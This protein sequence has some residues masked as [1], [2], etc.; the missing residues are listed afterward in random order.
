VT[1][2]VAP[3]SLAAAALRVEWRP[4]RDLEETAPAWRALAGRAL[5]A[6]VFYEPAFALAATPVFGRGA[7]AGLVW[8]SDKLIGFFPGRVTRRYGVPPAVLCGWAHP[9]AP[10][11]TPLIDRDDGAIALGAWLDW[12]AGNRSLPALWLL[13]FLS[14]GAFARALD[15]ALAIRRLPSVALGSHARAMLA[16]ANRT[17]Y[18]L[19]TVGS[20][21]RKEL[22]RQRRRLTDHGIVATEVADDAAALRGA[23]DD[24]LALEAGGWK[25]RAGTAIAQHPD[26]RSFVQRAVC[27]LA[28]EGKARADV[29]RVGGAPIAAALTLRSG[30]SAWTWKIA[31]DENY[32]PAS[33]G[34]QLMHDLTGS[35]L[36]D[37]TIARVDSC[38][39]AG[40]PMIDHLW[41]ERL[42]V[43]DRLIA[44]KPAPAAFAMARGLEALR[45]GARS[46]AKSLRD[47]VRRT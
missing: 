19:H 20:R 47:R 24:F 12:L 29:L 41:R 45:R 36:A 44:V 40:H 22:Q 3:A 42:T 11:G 28:A 10:L 15:A 37:V 35:L 8:L 1:V 46:A 33:P 16:P 7:S 13:P 32:A 21:K 2:A 6:N 27:T 9:F 38:A 39:T 31:Y 25:G 14:E 17:D 43:C 18:L 23:L 4:L 5:E 26:L 34:V 30:G